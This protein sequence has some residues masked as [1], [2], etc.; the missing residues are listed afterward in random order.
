MLGITSQPHDATVALGE[1]AT[2]SVGL[3]ESPYYGYKYKWYLNDR[4]LSYTST[5]SVVATEDLQNAR[6]YV[7]IYDGKY[8]D[9]YLETSNTAFLRI[10]K[11]TAVPVTVQSE[12]VFSLPS[13]I[14]AF[15]G[16]YVELS[17]PQPPPSKAFSI[18][19]FIDSVPLPNQI[20]PKLRL[21]VTYEL[22]NAEISVT[23]VSFAGS[24]RAATILHVY[25]A[26][27]II[28]VVV[29][30][31][32]ILT[33]GI[34]GGALVIKRRG[35]MHKTT[36]DNHKLVADFQPLHQQITTDSQDPGSTELELN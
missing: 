18:Q 28:A 11:P 9:K 7:G 27:W 26:K 34:I 12:V 30:I 25:W 6:V 31:G 19:W 36:T 16:E 23:M 17:V 22:D 35:Y 14:T 24:A 10:S 21:K 13:D 32:V 5:L 20:Y 1:T 15:S 29:V 8:A 2:F 33:A 4:I 3:K